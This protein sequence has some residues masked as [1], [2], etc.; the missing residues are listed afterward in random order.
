MKGVNLMKSTLNLNSMHN[1]LKH[2]ENDLE[3]LTQ[4]EPEILHKHNINAYTH[5]R[6]MKNMDNT[7][8][9]IE[10]EFDLI[11]FNDEKSSSDS[12]TTFDNENISDY[13]FMDDM[14]SDV[15]SKHTD[16]KYSPQYNLQSAIESRLQAK[17]NFEK[18]HNDLPK[19]QSNIIKNEDK[20]VKPNKTTKGLPPLYECSKNLLNRVRIINNDDKLYF[21]NGKCY[22]PVGKYDIAKLY[23]E[24]VDDK[25]GSSSS[26]YNIFQLEDFM[27]SDPSICVEDMDYNLHIAILNNGIYD[28]EKQQIFRH[29]SDIIAFSYIDADFVDDPYCPYFDKFLKN[30]FRNDPVLIERMWQVLGYLFMQT[31]EAKSFFLMGEAHDSGKSLLGNFIQS[32]Y[33]KQYVSN[34]PL[35]DFNTRF[36]S[37]RLVGSA[38]N[39]SLD[40]PATM[41]KDS[42]VSNQNEDYAL[43]SRIEFKKYLEKNV[44]LKH[45]KMR[46][47]GE[48]PQSAFKGIKLILD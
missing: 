3:S 25:I 15:S 38:I 18:L 7:L 4:I 2:L 31:N 22:D 21:F 8:N 47:G 27:L 1:L 40:L 20:L 16:D 19:K 23:R 42:A 36:G 35:H 13:E 29:T 37:V 33:P 34:I 24:K 17:N 39:I 9:Q 41:L 14:L 46:D 32:L 30:V 26:M 43:K 5:K 12:T 10:P 44:G 11:R 28:V 48:N 45:F 6:Y